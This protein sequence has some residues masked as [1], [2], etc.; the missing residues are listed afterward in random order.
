VA[1]KKEKGER[2]LEFL[3]SEFRAEEMSGFARLNRIPDSHVK[4]KLKRYRSLNEAQQES[5]A[6]CCAHWGYSCC[7]FVVDVPTLD[8]TQHPYFQQWSAVHS[9]LLHGDIE[10]DVPLLRAMVQQYKI[11]KFS[12]VPSSVTEEEFAYASSIRSVKAPELRRRFRAALKPLGYLRVDGLGYYQCRRFN[13]DFAVHVDY[14]GRHAQ[15]RYVVSFPEFRE[16][17]PLTQFGFERTLGFGFGDWDFIVEENV[18][19][20]IALFQEVVA[21]SFELPERIRRAVHYAS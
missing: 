6:D 19:D 7:S 8:H 3:R 14:G 1:S 13:R 20:A 12:G 10:Q 9:P 18:E 2:L 5:F 4:A 17:H 11:D 21:Y 15:L 16:R